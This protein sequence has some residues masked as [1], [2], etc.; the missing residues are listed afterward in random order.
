[1]YLQ[2][3]L[4]LWAGGM[5]LPFTHL[6]FDVLAG[7]LA[8]LTEQSEFCIDCVN[9]DLKIGLEYDGQDYHQDSGKDKRRRNALEGLGWHVFPIDKSVLYDSEA[10]YRAGLQIAKRMGVR[11]RLPKRWQ[12]KNTQLRKDLGLPV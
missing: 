1:M 11:V 4:P 5:G 10:T 8:H 12:E 6:N 3:G 9:S 2:F 7:R